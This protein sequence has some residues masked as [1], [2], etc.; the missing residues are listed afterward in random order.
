M[1]GVE[2]PIPLPR[3]PNFENAWL[4][5]PGHVLRGTYGF[6]AAMNY[7]RSRHLRIAKHYERRRRTTTGPDRVDPPDPTF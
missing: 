4:Q 3:C 6:R 5:P 2:P 1:E 7:A